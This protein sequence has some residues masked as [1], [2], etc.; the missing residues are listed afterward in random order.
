MQIPHDSF[1]LVADGRKSLFFRNQGATFLLSWSSSARTPMPTARIG[2]QERRA[3]PRLRQQ[4]RR[5]LRA[6]D[7]TDFHQ[8]EDPRFA[9]ETAANAEGAGAR[10]RVRIADRGGA[11]AHARRASGSIITRKSTGGSPPRCRRIWSRSGRRDRED[12]ARGMIPLCTGKEKPPRPDG[13]DAACFVAWL[14]LRAVASRL[15]SRLRHQGAAAAPNSRII[16]GAGTCVPPVELDE[17]PLDEELELARAGGAAARR[18][19]AGAAG[20][21]RAAEAA[22]SAGRARAGRGAEVEPPECRAGA[23]RGD[24]VEL[25]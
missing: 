3:R 11:A 22:R 10:Q 1:V 6:F 9:A 8:Q 12:P 20:A 14:A 17:P 25:W 4:R 24:E 19:G 21:A 13:P 7:E 18:G 16:G 23:G 5:P 2:D 15:P